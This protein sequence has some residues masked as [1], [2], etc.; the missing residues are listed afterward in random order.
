MPICTAEWIELHVY[1]IYT[2]DILTS[3]QLD[4]VDTGW[5]LETSSNQLDTFHS[6]LHQFEVCMFHWDMPIKDENTPII[7][8]FDDVL[9][10]TYLAKI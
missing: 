7:S 1:V 9:Y 5:L 2:Y 6:L 8:S 3:I 4:M 10:I